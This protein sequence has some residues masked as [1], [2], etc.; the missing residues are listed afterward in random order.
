M[1]RSA[2]GD[3]SQGH[4]LLPLRNVDRSCTNQ[5]DNMER[6]HQVGLMADI[7]RQATHVLIWIGTIGLTEIRR[8]FWSWG[9][10]NLSQKP[11]KY[12]GMPWI[13]PD[14][15][16]DIRESQ[17]WSRAWICQENLLA[18]KALIFCWPFLLPLESLY[19]K[20]NGSRMVTRGALALV[21]SRRKG[22]ISAGDRLGSILQD[23]G[24]R[25]T[26]ERK[27]VVYSLL[28]LLSDESPPFHVDYSESN[29]L[30]WMRTVQDVCTEARGARAWLYN[31]HTSAFLMPRLGLKVGP[32]S[33]LDSREEL[34]DLYANRLVPRLRPGLLGGDVSKLNNIESL[35]DLCPHRLG[36]GY[37]VFCRHFLAR[38]KYDPII[39]GR[40]VP[41]NPGTYSRSA[42]L[43][44]VVWEHQEVLPLVQQVVTLE[45]FL[46]GCCR[47][48]ESLCQRPVWHW[49]FVSRYDSYVWMQILEDSGDQAVSLPLQEGY[50]LDTACTVIQDAPCAATRRRFDDVLLSEWLPPNV[51]L[52]PDP[53]NDI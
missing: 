8:R 17:Y 25:N 40:P 12:F 27:D 33:K 16:S 49:R 43:L 29:I 15:L 28:G 45:G 18:K 52:P 2:C 32:V 41:P 53:E 48:C 42:E 23:L 47:N 1:L 39:L 24:H 4:L 11:Y 13:L 38:A 26:T 6:N 35:V 50:Y 46:E 44:I 30:C 36:M 22:L 51:A 31:K 20:H 7:Y 21:E 3:S 19:T 5:L 34:L 37:K 10:Y 9:Q 14:H